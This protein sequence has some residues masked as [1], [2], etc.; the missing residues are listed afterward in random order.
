MAGIVS[1][2]SVGWY[3][4]EETNDI[5]DKNWAFYNYPQYTF[6]DPS[7]QALVFQFYHFLF[8]SYILFS[9]RPHLQK[10]SGRSAA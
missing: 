5:H 2:R 1:L 4:D 3:S 6:V 9:L 10:V 8:C 7:I